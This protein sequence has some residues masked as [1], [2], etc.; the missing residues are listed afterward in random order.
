MFWMTFSS[1]SGYGGPEMFC[2]PEMV[3]LLCDWDVACVYGLESGEGGSVLMGLMCCL[4]CLYLWPWTSMIYDLGMLAQATMVPSRYD[5]WF[6]GLKN[7]PSCLGLRSGRGVAL[8]PLSYWCF[9]ADF[10]VI[11]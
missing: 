5:I 10:L 6:I 4:L 9:W 2:G 8:C 3:G 11:R 7:R 1:V